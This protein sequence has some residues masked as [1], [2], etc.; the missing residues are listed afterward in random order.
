[1]FGTNTFVNLTVELETN[2]VQV[3]GEFMQL[4][5]TRYLLILHLH[6]PL[7]KFWWKEHFSWPVC[8]SLLFLSFI[9]LDEF[10][11]Y[12][13]DFSY[14]LGPSICTTGPIIKHPHQEGTLAIK[15]KSTLI[16]HNYLKSIVYFGVHFQFCP[17]N[18][19][20]QIYNS[21]YLPFHTMYFHWPK[22]P[23]CSTYPFP[24]DQ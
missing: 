1:M 4:Q 22:S 17:F 3:K 5:P 6:N 11:V 2:K 9:F 7:L 13:I 21:I 24:A 19:C 18:G 10:L 12:G 16:H 23:L 14:T 20:E 8:F 15:D